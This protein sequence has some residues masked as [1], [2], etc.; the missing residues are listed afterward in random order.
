MAREIRAGGLNMSNEIRA[1][2]ADAE[3]QR[4]DKYQRRKKKEEAQQDFMTKALSTSLKTY[5]KQKVAEARWEDFKPYMVFDNRA[6]QDI[7]VKRPT[8]RE[9]LHDVFGLGR[10]KFRDH[11]PDILR[12]VREN[13]LLRSL[14]NWREAKAKERGLTACEL[15]SDKALEA[16]LKKRPA[17]EEELR[18]IHGLKSKIGGMGQDILE[19]ILEIVRST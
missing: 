3:R 9:E 7:L 4:R 12:L 1:R 11:G 14:N 18:N 6:L 15:F 16:I 17:T 8:T 5:K 13:E 10:K 19:D 2:E